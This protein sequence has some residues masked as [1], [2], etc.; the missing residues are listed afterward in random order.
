MIPEVEYLQKWK[1]RHVSL[2]LKT[3][4]TTSL[5]WTPELLQPLPPDILFRF[6]L[7]PF[8]LVEKKKITQLTDVQLVFEFCWE[9]WT[10]PVIFLFAIVCDDNSNHLLYDLLPLAQ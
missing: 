3:L 7:K 1:D 10:V 9:L 2:T 8:T 6:L 4:G 5:S